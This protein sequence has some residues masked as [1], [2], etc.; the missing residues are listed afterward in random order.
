MKNET[1]ILAK[2]RE[3]ID[4]VKSKEITAQ[5]AQARL[6]KLAGELE[7][8]QWQ[9]IDDLRHRAPQDEAELARAIAAVLEAELRKG[10]GNA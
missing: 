9:I 10:S 2:F 3:I 5:E 4:L 8:D 6:R 7:T 1:D